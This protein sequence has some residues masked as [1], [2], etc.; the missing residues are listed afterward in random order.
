MIQRIQSVWLLVATLLI[1]LTLK[2]SFYSGTHMPP[3]NQYHQLN[4]MDNILLMMITIAAGVLTLITIFLFKTR[5]I[6]LRLCI[7]AILLDLLLIFLY[8]RAIRDF[9]KGEYAITAASHIIIIIA[10]ILAA[11]GINR[12][13]KL[14]RDSNRLR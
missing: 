11:R 8:I 3:D 1:F 12:D 7:V 5:I 13:E 4:G 9:T 10:L 2:F 6:Q 14:I